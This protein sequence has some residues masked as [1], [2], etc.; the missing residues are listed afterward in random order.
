MG[1][2]Q[3]P[4]TGKTRSMAC[5][6]CGASQAITGIESRCSQCGTLLTPPTGR[7][8][9]VD[10]SLSAP[11]DPLSVP[12]PSVAG[13]LGGVSDGTQVTHHVTSADPGKPVA[14]I[15]E[16]PVGRSTDEAQAMDPPAGPQ[17]HVERGGSR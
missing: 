14:P 7:M 13:G 11:M 8:G 16:S 10:A 12:P 6:N 1:H 5:P 4:I 17:A 15:A 2:G 3:T 9:S